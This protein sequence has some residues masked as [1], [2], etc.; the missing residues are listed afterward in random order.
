MS[1]IVNPFLLVLPQGLPDP[2]DLL[3]S[4]DQKESLEILVQLGL[5][6]QEHVWFRPDSWVLV[7]VPQ[8][9]PRLCGLMCFFVSRSW[10]TSWVKWRR[11]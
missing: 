2:L 9:E 3:G 5:Q 6:V 10:W 11:G 4:E 7:Q 1:D 8:S